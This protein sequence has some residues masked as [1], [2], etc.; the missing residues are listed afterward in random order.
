MNACCMVRSGSAERTEVKEVGKAE[1]AGD[2]A[3]E[4]CDGGGD[5]AACSWG[6]GDLT[7]MRT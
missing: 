2:G 6:D 7:R 3:C 4:L 1:V 5:G